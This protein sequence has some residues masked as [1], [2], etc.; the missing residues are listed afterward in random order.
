MIKT[1][2]QPAGI[3]DTNDHLP[4]KRAGRPKG[5]KN[6]HR[7]GKVIVVKNKAS[8]KY[9]KQE[10]IAIITPL[11][12]LHWKAKKMSWLIRNIEKELQID[13]KYISPKE[14]FSLLNDMEQVYTKLEE[15]GIAT[16]EQRT[17]TRSRVKSKRLAQEGDAL[18]SSRMGEDES[19]SV[20]S[21]IPTSHPF[22]G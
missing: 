6:I 13:P 1:D 8:D 11:I 2:T 19:A 14:Y 7:N 9:Q 22:G 10:R 21:G 17:A 5:S 18:K 15:K 20:G 12:P 4:K 16:S 3:T